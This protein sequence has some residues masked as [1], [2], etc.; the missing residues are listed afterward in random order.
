MDEARRN[1]AAKR[2]A[3]LAGLEAV[4]NRVTISQQFRPG[5]V[6]E[7]PTEDLPILAGAV[8]SGCTH[9]WT[10]DKRHF[11]RWY[12]KPL[13]GVVVVDSNLIARQL[14]DGGW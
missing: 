1:L 2:P 8:G 10:G 4:L 12:G 3:H 7:L 11:G 14:L 6:V 5:L 9:L 13:E